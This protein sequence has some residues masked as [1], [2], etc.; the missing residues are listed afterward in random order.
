MNNLFETIKRFFTR[1]KYKLAGAREGRDVYLDRPARGKRLG[2][3]ILIGAL[4]IILVTVFSI[5]SLPGSMFYSLK[6]EVIEEIFGSMKVST[7][8]K[9]AYQIKLLE[10]RLSELA[11]MNPEK[12]VSEKAQGQIGGKIQE[13]Y[14]TLKS[15]IESGAD[16]SQG[17]LV[18]TLYALTTVLYLHDHVIAQNDHLEALEDPAG[19]RLKEARDIYKGYVQIYVAASEADEIQSF[20]N[21][22]LQLLLNR[23]D[24]QEPNE[25]TLEK[26]N[27]R[28]GQIQTAIVE[29]NAAEAIYLVHESLQ[30]LRAEEYFLE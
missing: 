7:E 2:M 22:Q 5:R 17:N 13:N 3:I 6:T 1:L 8:G 28:L 9:E 21:N 27:R 24:D 30:L 25:E 4:A 20:I 11:R 29:N 26:I 10:R 16:A 15:I 12:E 19:D 18:N 23:V 14:D